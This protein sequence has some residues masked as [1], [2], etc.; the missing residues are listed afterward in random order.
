MP[1]SATGIW[2]VAKGVTATGTTSLSIAP[3]TG[4]TDD[5][6][7]VMHLT[8]RG[9]GFATVPAG[10]T[11]IEQGV[12]ATTG[13]RAEA[14]WKR[15]AT[16]S[17]NYSV[18]GLADSS[19]GWVE[20][21]RGCLEAGDVIDASEIS[22]N[23][24]AVFNNIVGPLTTTVANTM[25]VVQGGNGSASYSGNTIRVGNANVEP[26]FNS[27]PDL[28]GTNSVGTGSNTT[29]SDSFLIARYALKPVAGSTINPFYVV[30]GPNV[31]N[32]CIAFALKP[33]VTGTPTSGSRYYLGFGTAGFLGEPWAL[34]GAWA[35]CFVD[36]EPSF[37]I[38]R[39]LELTQYKAGK[40]D[41][42]TTVG[43]DLT[44][45]IVVTNQQGNFDILWQRFMTPPL[46]GQ[47]L[48]GTINTCIAFNARW[49]NTLG[50]F[51]ANSTCRLKIHVYTTVG[52]TP[53]V[54]NV[55]VNNYINSSNLNNANANIVWE[56]LDVAQ[57]VATTI[58][59][60]D[61]IVVEVGV[62]V[63]SSL[64]PTPTYPPSEWTE[65]KIIGLGTE[66]SGTAWP[67]DPTAGTTATSPRDQVAY[68][69]FSDTITEQ[70]LPASPTNISP[71][72]ATDMGVLPYVT[73]AGVNT[74]GCTANARAL[75]YAFTSTRDGF[76]IFRSAGTMGSAV[77]D[78]YSGD[79]SSYSTL[80]STL[81]STTVASQD[82]SLTR[83]L[84][85]WACPVTEGATYYMRVYCRA[86]AAV[87]SKAS[88]QFVQVAVSYQEAPEAGDVFLPSHAIT[89]W[90]DGTL[91]NW[92]NSLENFSPSGITIDYTQRPMD[93]LNGGVNTNYRIFVA[94]FST[95]LIEIFDLTTLNRAQQEIDFINDPLELASG[96]TTAHLAALHMT[97]DGTLY[98]QTMGNGFLY[99]MG[100]LGGIP[101]DLTEV[102]DNADLSYVRGM[103]GTHADNQTGAPWPLADEFD[104]TPDETSPWHGGLDQ[105]RSILYYG[106]GGTYFTL[107]NPAQVA[108]TFNVS[109][110]TQGANFSTE[111][112]S[113]VA[114]GLKGMCVSLAGDVFICNGNEIVQRD[115]TGTLVNTFDP[116]SDYPVNL[117]DVRMDPDGLHIWALDGSTSDLFQFEI[118][119]TTQT[120]YVQ[121]WQAVGGSL[122]IAVFGE[123]VVPPEDFT[124][125]TETRPI[126]WLR[127]SPHVSANMD[128][129]FHNLFMLDMEVGVGLREDQGV[130]P[131]VVLQVSKDGG[132]TWGAARELGMGRRGE[133]KKLM[134]WWRQGY[135]RDFVY[136]VYG[137]DPV[138]VKIVGAYISLE[139]GDN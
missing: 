139:P 89:A 34:S 74:K 110:N 22:V 125:P 91:V 19:V 130:N 30:G 83:A 133:Y 11:L 14:Y 44:T 5:D 61:S 29:G 16:E 13:I 54:R 42:A 112:A 28:A 8:H 64:T 48:S 65:I 36:S 136:R 6:I 18:T 10:F 45:P 85:A 66:H 31:E 103:D 7:I 69:D 50:V 131:L 126:R 49:R 120:Q 96:R 12:T 119:S 41:F 47:T 53:V 35:D 88:G 77:V 46:A 23:A 98:V 80:T 101:A 122:Q 92:Q 124:I 116:V 87:T 39:T 84:A 60:G 3:Y 111:S 121:T 93:D 95:S 123:E 25:V 15:A 37:E 137:S 32:I 58:T 57:S 43:G 72:T 107:P 97:T 67:A 9:A 105:A 38:F 108:K 71:M 27:D 132:H 75:W 55:L 52:Q 17:G 33:E 73:P 115:S 24:A 106:S 20:G 129:S 62:R 102:S 79:G 51:S 99:V 1:I 100:V 56:D 90:R 109:G 4:I 127:Q 70:A 78:V 21:F 81:G 63:V 68:L 94:L 114:Q 86:T 117:F 118:E 76:A 40:G 104:A 26:F 134:R 135:G 128:R 59:A 82:Q 113:G 138:P 2:F